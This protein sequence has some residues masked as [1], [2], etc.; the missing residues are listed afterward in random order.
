MMSRC[1]IVAW[2]VVVAFSAMAADRPEGW[3]EYRHQEGANL[4]CFWYPPTWAASGHSGM[5]DAWSSGGDAVAMGI[6]APVSTPEGFQ[7]FLQMTRTSLVQSG[8][9]PMLV[10]AH[11]QSIIA[12]QEKNPV[13]PTP[14]QSPVEV[15]TE[16]LP[17]VA[18]R[19]GRQ[20]TGVQLLESIP[21]TPPP[22]NPTGMRSSI[23]RVNYLQDGVPFRGIV[24]VSTAWVQA[25]TQWMFRYTS[26][27][28]PANRF[29]QS[30]P[31]M[32]KIWESYLSLSALGDWASAPVRR[33]LEEME[34][35]AEAWDNYIR[36]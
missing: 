13:P 11:M 5:G 8:M 24:Q 16:T 15:V 26:L 23:C 9:N 28:A 32:L 21:L 17:R 18:A 29:G 34:R 20:I 12:G 27:A 3:K 30:L 1:G 14:F 35:W 7:M 31:D 36:D 25:P 10:Q 4:T 22:F 2:I 6:T 33:R 19:M